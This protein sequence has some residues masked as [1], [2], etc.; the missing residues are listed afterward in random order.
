MSELCVRMA[1]RNLPN[2]RQGA[3]IWQICLSL[4]I[5]NAYIRLRR[6]LDEPSVTLRDAERQIRRNG[7]VYFT[8]LE[9]N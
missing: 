1:K 7:G 8:T 9:G 6:I 5:A 2:H 3:K 4:R